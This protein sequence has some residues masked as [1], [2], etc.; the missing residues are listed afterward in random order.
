MDSYFLY[1]DPGIGSLAAQVIIAGFAAFMMFF[2]NTFRRFFS[3]RKKE[4]KKENH[5]KI[6]E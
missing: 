2:R 1:I 5:E 3:F 6:S 4:E